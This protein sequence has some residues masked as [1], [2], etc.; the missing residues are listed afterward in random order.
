MK[1]TRMVLS[2]LALLAMAVSILVGSAQGADV[3]DTL[4]SAVDA[5]TA[6]PTV[7]TFIKETLIPHCTN[8][9]FVEQ[10][11][12]QNAKGLSL[13]AIKATDQQWADAEEE[14]TIHE[15][16][17][18]NP[19][20]VEVTKIANGHSAISET[21]VMDNQGANV[22][23]NDLTSDYWQGDEPKW[24]NSFNH[25]QGGIDIG[26]EKLDKSTN[27]VMQQISLPIIDENG[28]V[29]G[30]VTFGINTGAL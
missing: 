12:T 23:Q 6:S 11:Q 30:A 13:D 22:G 1:S 27:Q 7:K 4:I 20:A 28:S 29:I 14:L 3:K 19:C 21:F 2:T 17:T 25:G 16:L 24:Q 8:P 5:S 9:V 26:K 18:T 15:E 10:V